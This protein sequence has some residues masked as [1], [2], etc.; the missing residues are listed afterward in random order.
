MSQ[1][2]T[3]TGEATSQDSAVSASSPSPFIYPIRSAVSVKPMLRNPSSDSA[4]LSSGGGSHD[5]GQSYPSDDERTAL[6]GSSK[7]SDMNRQ[8]GDSL[9]SMSL[10][11]GAQVPENAQMDEDTE[12]AGSSNQSWSE[13]GRPRSRASHESVE[14]SRMMKEGAEEMNSRASSRLDNVHLRR[15]DGNTHLPPSDGDPSVNDK[16][17]MERMTQPRFRHVET[18]EGHMI[19]TGRDG[20]IARCEDE[21]IHIP[22]A[23]QSFGCMV[24]TR[25]DSEGMLVVRQVSEVSGRVGLQAGGVRLPS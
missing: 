15:T 14:D 5:G 21:P 17:V 2:P 13:E 6:P 23:V 10:S 20:E 8:L 3:A 11:D 25:E 1:R 22:G 12:D 9:N 24:V 4:S 18:E 7:Q 19:V 16:D